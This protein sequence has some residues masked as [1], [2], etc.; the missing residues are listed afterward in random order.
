MKILS[1]V[2]AC[3]FCIL[4]VISGF[5][6][7]D[8]LTFQDKILPG[9]FIEKV[10]VGGLTEEE[11]VK[12]LETIGIDKALSTPITLKLEDRRIEF[13]PS[14]VGAVA[15]LAESVEEAYKLSHKNY[16]PQLIWQRLFRKKVLLP[17]ILTLNEKKV[18]EFFDDISR[19]IDSPPQDASVSV[20]NLEKILVTEERIG[21]NLEVEAT[22]KK[23]KEAIKEGRRE[24]PLVITYTPPRLF[25]RDIMEHPPI[26]ILGEFTTYY[27]THDSPNRIHNIHLVTEILNHKILPPEEKFSL[28]D[29][30]GEISPEKGFKEAFVIIGAALTPEAGGGTCQIATTLYN[31]VLLGDLEVLQRANHAV[32]FSIYPLGLDAAVYPPKT[33]FKFKN[34]TKFPIV[35]QA[36]AN[37]KKLTIRIF[38]SPQAKKV[39]FS[40][41]E[42]I[43]LD[44]K[45]AKVEALIAS[46]A[47]SE[48]VEAAEKAFTIKVKRT[49][50]QEGRRIKEEEIKSFYRLH[51]DKHEVKI[52]RPE[53]R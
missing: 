43:M 47:P 45:Q 27:G 41:P 36:L 39:Y 6:A 22:L 10:E 50:I 4:A 40:S 44:E 46:G 30:V 12:Q 21:R 31:A 28:L 48:E 16:L 33:D 2:L 29:T 1:L 18:K 38:G 3:L 25:A 42:E 19:S 52:E 14:K 23:I 51:G 9:Y 49:V 11:A 17:L 53:P 37:Q 13:L 15:E 7:S 24:V 8:C 35:L 5:I 26:D 34:S 32:Y 20:E